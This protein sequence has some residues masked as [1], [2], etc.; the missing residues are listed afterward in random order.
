MKRVPVADWALDPVIKDTLKEVEG[1]PELAF[2]RNV[3]THWL[4]MQKKF[5]AGEAEVANKTEVPK[6]H[7]Q[8]KSLIEA[9][10]L[11]Q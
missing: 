8:Q 11:D 5:V 6:L 4:N 1:E 10:H 7:I 9:G 3:K 2:D